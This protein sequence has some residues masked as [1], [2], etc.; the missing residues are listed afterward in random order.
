VSS[1]I[2]FSIKALDDFSA[3]MNKLHGTLSKTE[4]A[5]A[6]LGIAAGIYTAVGA[7]RASL[8][9]AEA[10]GT[11]AMKANMTTEAFSA[12]AWAAKM[13]NV[14]QGSLATG[15]KFL[16]KAMAE[17]DATPAG[18][19]LKGLGIAAR[20]AQGNLR[21]TIDVLLDVS[22]AFAGAKDD[23]SKTALAMKLFGRSGVDM[24]PMLNGNSKA[25]RGLMEDAKKLGVVI[26]DDFAKSADQVNDNL[27]TLSAVMQGSVNGAMAQLSPVIEQIT[28]QFIDLATSGDSVKQ[29]GDVIATAMRLI[30]TAGIFV[31]GVFKTVGDVVGG[32]IAGIVLATNG[33]WTESMEA[34]R[35]TSLDLAANVT[36]TVKQMGAVWDEN[37][38]SVAAAEA[39]KMTA[40]RKGAAS[41]QDNSKAVEDARKKTEELQK[42]VDDAT[43]SLAAAN[44]TS[45]LG[46]ELAKLMELRLRGATDAQ[47]AHL[48][49]LTADKLSQDEWNATQTAATEL[50]GGLNPI[51]TEHEAN[52][53]KIQEVRGELTDGQ[54]AEAMDLENERWQKAQAAVEWYGVSVASVARG[55]GDAMAQTVVDGASLAKGLENVAK[56]V[57]KTVISTLVQIGVQRLILSALDHGATAA[58]SSQKMAAGM[59][60]V[61]VNSFASAAA[62]PVVGWAIA[63]QVATANTALAMAGAASSMAAGA[64]LGGIA[65]GGMDFVPSESTFLLDK[66]E[67]V[68]SPRQNT[69]LTD[70]LSEGGSG[71][72]VVI[73]SLTIH[74][75]ENATS[76]DVFARMDKIAL[77]NALGQPVVDALNEMFSLGVRPNFAMQNNR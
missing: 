37:A 9:N 45:G 39:R 76:A 5:F 57:L 6:S 34:F 60:E 73:E 47:L 40:L 51:L 23:A 1:V 16:G 67:R 2:E 22:D 29:A 26:S 58:L 44:A 56:T 25:I 15:L 68:L 65:H 19:A 77:R 12:L 41:L 17:G 11:A 27:A 72:S 3:N 14:E 30:M 21:P 43:N 75:L 64:G 38:Q 63:P 48:E 35:A 70:F 69:D 66:G 42:A 49:A 28:G 54:F 13:S 33:K 8:D 10:M 71:Q 46:S 50:I 24:V 7:A 55:I 31:V 61:F 18:A 62:I 4:K 36:G 74:V 52:L 53:R 32:V 20:D 59:G